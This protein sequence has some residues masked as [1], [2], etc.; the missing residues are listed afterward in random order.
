MYANV[1]HFT[2]I[3]SGQN[4][5]QLFDMLS[6]IINKL[7]ARRSTWNFPWINE[8]NNLAI[9]RT[10]DNRTPLAFAV[11]HPNTSERIVELLLTL[12][13]SPTIE[14]LVNQLSP[15]LDF[16]QT[17]LL[18]AIEQVAKAKRRVTKFGHL[19]PLLVDCDRKIRNQLFHFPCRHNNVNLLKWLIN[20]SSENNDSA[21]RRTLANQNINLNESDHAGYTP[22]L[23]AV[24]YKST[25]C[26][27]HLSQVSMCCF[28]RKKTIFNDECRKIKSYKI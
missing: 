16:Y 22:L 18:I 19:Y 20:P 4:E 11:C 14:I 28:Y 24:F 17:Q 3:P 8:Q 12:N 6:Y 9:M 25:E 1:L 7:Q 13:E 5:K 15:K 10:L 23:T 27:Q 26:F 21:K 2:F